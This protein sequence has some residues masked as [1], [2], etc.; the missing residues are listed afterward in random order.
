M[1]FTDQN[2]APPAGR[3]PIFQ[4]PR[5]VVGSIAVLAA[6]H[7]GLWWAGESWQIWSLYTLAFIP[8]RLANTGFPVLQGSQVWSFLTYTLL[9][10]GWGHLA[11]NCLWLLV[12][13]TP[14]ARFMGAW[15]FLA[16]AAIAAV[17]GAVAALSMH[18]GEQYIMVGASGSISGLMGAAVPIMFGGQR[19]WLTAM[20]GNPATTL[21]LSPRQLLGNRNAVMFAVVWLV[22]TLVSGASAWTGNSF[23]PEGGIAWEDHIGGFFGGIAAFYMLWRDWMRQP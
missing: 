6:I 12:F 21:P 22:I 18:W 4:A 1:Q 17:T 16:I 8:A 5:I 9:H 15:R 14:V 2:M 3:E 23:V 13:G 11:A 20:V 19:G 7:A 10:G